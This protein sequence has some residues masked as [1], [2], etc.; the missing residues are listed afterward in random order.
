MQEVFF[1]RR[2]KT[3]ICPRNSEEC[4]IAVISHYI[5]CSEHIAFRLETSRGRKAPI[6]VPT[7]LL[8]FFGKGI[9][10]CSTAFLHIECIR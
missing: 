9:W 2:F 5:S 8:Y 10:K 3:N 4:H 6:R 7:V 1:G